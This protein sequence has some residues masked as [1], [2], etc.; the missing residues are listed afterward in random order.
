M[1]A[2]KNRYL[3]STFIAV[4]CLSMFV[5]FYLSEEVENLTI[6][7]LTVRPSSSP[8]ISTRVRSA[9]RRKSFGKYVSPL[10]LWK[11]NNFISL[12][13]QYMGLNLSLNERSFVM[14]YF[15]NSSL[16]KP[17]A[18]TWYG[19][20]LHGSRCFLS[21]ISIISYRDIH[22]IIYIT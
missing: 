19:Y 10:S 6:K 11:I 22:T 21:I 3:Y 13:I 15:G 2:L 18:W 7:Q 14:I 8:K 12:V 17:F 5:V 20:F 4:Q 9:K 16:A 1:V